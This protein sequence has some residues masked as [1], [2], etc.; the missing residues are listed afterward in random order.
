MQLEE[1]V[2]HAITEAEAA[3]F[4]RE[5]YGL[6]VIARSLPGE[7]D[8]NF[9]L[10]RTDEMVTAAA[11]SV[12]AAEPPDSSDSPLSAPAFVLKVMHPAR[13]RTLIDLQCRALQ[14]LAERAPHIRLP[15]VCSARSGELFTQVTATDGSQRLVWLLTYIPEKFWRKRG[16]IP[17]NCSP[18]WA[19]CWGKSMARWRIFHTPRRIAS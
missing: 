17:T 5:L 15:R 2:G 16:R 18:A 14:H 3:Q 8:D 12:S 6:G 13:D 9:Q 4:A 1:R 11:T 10:T 7:Y 19:A